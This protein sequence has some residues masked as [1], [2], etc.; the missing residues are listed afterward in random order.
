MMKHIVLAGGGHAHLTTLLRIQSL[1]GQGHRVTLISPSPYHYYS[2]MG[3]GML[4]GIYRPQEIRFNIKK[5]AEDRSTAFV[6]GTVVR[7]VPKE[8]VLHL[9]SGEQV[10]YD[11]VSFNIGSKVPM[12]LTTG[13]MECVFPVK[14]IE[15]LLRARERIL[16]LGKEDKP[17]LI[18]VG[19][20]PASLELSGSLWRLVHDQ[21]GDGRIRVLAGRRF[22]ARFPERVRRLA[23]RSLESRDIEIVEGSYVQEVNPGRAILKDG[24]EFQFDLGLLALGIKPPDLFKDSG[25]PTGQDG[26]MLVNRYLQSVAYPEIFGG[27]DCISFQEQPLD[28][29]GVYAVRQNPILYQNI[30]QAAAGGELSAFRPGESYMLIFNLGDGRGIY[31]R[32]NWIMEGKLAFALKD[33]ID[34]RF[35]RKFQVSGEREE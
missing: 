28:K 31:W 1:I 4:A 2:G 17:S 30:S 19:G 23:M 11:I 14:P 6:C 13:S 9:D 22:L 21:G 33:W 12:D 26:G 27:G 29:V 7:I 32:R 5:A 24:R 3:P 18:V 25:L 20:G 16:G 35:M 15:N 8:R 34:R 10:N